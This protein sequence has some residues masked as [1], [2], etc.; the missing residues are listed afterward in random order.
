MDLRARIQLEIEGCVVDARAIQLLR[1]AASAGSLSAAA[2]ELDVSYR[3]AWGLFRELE[4]ATG[5][6]LLQTTRGRGAVVTEAGKALCE[7]EAQVEAALQPSLHRVAAQLKAAWH[8]GARD[9]PACTMS[10]SHDLALAELREH[11][12]KTGRCSIELQFQGSTASL[13]ALA[14][15][16][17]ELAGFHF[18]DT[19]ARS[20]LAGY[21]PY[22][23]N[24]DLRLLHFVSRR[25]GLIVRRGNPLGIRSLADLVRTKA[26]FVNRQKGSGTRLLLDHQLAVSGIDA[27]RI[28]G[29][30]NEEFTHVAVAA[31]V[32]SGMAD[33]GFG[34]EPAARQQRLD[35]IPVAREHYYIAGSATAF[36]SGAPAALLSALT[37]GVLQKLIRKLPGYEAPATFSPR[38]AGDLV[39]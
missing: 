13:A 14:A 32:A 39:G 22:L 36:A 20:Q 3:H 33:A 25:Q 38:R 1:A 29:Y 35:F 27:H 28:V 9:V 23:K 37:G 18:P 31:M 30:G 5:V 19:D 10:A 34:I 4:A 15:G 26:H 7:A 24:R 11:L 17:C 12:A 2:R 16:R 21:R 8:A 6:P